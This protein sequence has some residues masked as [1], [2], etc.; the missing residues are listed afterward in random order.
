MRESLKNQGTR[1]AVFEPARISPE[2]FAEAFA[3]GFDRVA[4]HLASGDPGF[5][6]VGFSQGMERSVVR[7][8][9]LGRDSAIEPVV[10]GRHECA[11]LVLSS[12]EALSL[13]H[14]LVLLRVDGEGRP[15]IRVLD[16]RSGVGIADAEGRFHYSIAADGPVCLS[17][18]SSALLVIPSGA[19]PPLGAGP[20]AA[21][22]AINW[23]QPVP[24][25]PA[26]SVEQRLAELSRE[27]GSSS[28]VSVVIGGTG[29]GKPVIRRRGGRRAGR[30]KLEF[31]GQSYEH[32]VDTYALRAGVLVG[33]YDR[34]DLSPITVAMPDVVSRVHLLLVSIEE[35]THIFDTGSTN[36]LTYEGFP[37]RGMALPD[38]HPAVFELADDVKMTWWP[39]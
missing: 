23:P 17:L 8:I 24:W 22:D 20:K 15:V 11:D 26:H 7:Q 31:D 4:A 30:L 28:V 13:R 39:G 2:L 19:K 35:R 14:T 33:R 32:P 25:I 27:P 29:A 34:C 1:I 21:F 3:R 10:V 37:V 5:V 6:V 36:G 16:L 9:K 18:A 12:N 38:S